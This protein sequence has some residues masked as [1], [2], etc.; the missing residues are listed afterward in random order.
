MGAK[1]SQF[2]NRGYGTYLLKEKFKVVANRMN[3][4]IVI[5][6]PDEDHYNFLQASF[7]G[8]LLKQV[9]EIVIG[10]KFEDYG[11]TFKSWVSET[12]NMPP[13]YTVNNGS[14][15]Y[16]NSDC[17]WTLVPVQSNIGRSKLSYTAKYR[18]HTDMSM[19]D[20]DP[21]QFCG[22]DV[23]ISVLGANICVR[24]KNKPKH[25]IYDNKNARS[26][27]L[28]LAYKEWS[29]FLSGDFEGERQQRK[30]IN[31]WSP[32]VL[33]STYYKV[34]HHGAW[35]ME[36]QANLPYL[37][38]IIRPKR[39]YVSQA[40]PIMT[41]CVKYL[42]PRCE[43][44]EHL[45]EIGTIDKIDSSARNSIVCWEDFGKR[46]GRI[47]QRSGYAIYETCREYDTDLDKQICHDIMITT[48]GYNDHTT[49]VGVPR[50]YLYI[51]EHFQPSRKCR[52]PLEDLKKQ[53]P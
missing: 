19:M 15:C 46:S 28:K 7:D 14:E 31:Q 18:H 20:G 16:G 24:D 33:Q 11:K 2:T 3:I 5:T 43:V 50:E 42:H 8:E 4:H 37:L 13:V 12:D 38:N 44:I 47:E 22:G 35:R 48:D 51:R 40:H 49:Y 52:K 23:G 1:I 41:F 25:C 10:S 9:K 32:K 53:L 30:F 34:A 45:L 39:A 6:H 29:L 21:W 17:R 26:V 36:E 27:I